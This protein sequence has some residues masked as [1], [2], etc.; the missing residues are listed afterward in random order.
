MG[1]S[2]ELRKYR[3]GIYSDVSED[4]S[5]AS[6]AASRTEAVI[7]ALA[8]LDIPTMFT[9]LSQC[10]SSALNASSISIPGR[11]HPLSVW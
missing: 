11:A 6:A 4:R 5:V 8:V 1:S 7:S 3:P 9:D 10:L 2:D